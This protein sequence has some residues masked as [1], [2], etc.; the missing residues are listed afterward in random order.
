[1]AHTN[2]LRYV[3]RLARDTALA[4]AQEEPAP[5][6]ISR[7]EVLGG[8]VAAAATFMLPRFSFG[9]PDKDA[10]I[11]VVGAGISGLS[12]A[13]TLFD[14]GFGK[15]TTVYEASERIGGRMFSNSSVINANGAG[16]PGLAGKTYWDED[17][18]TEW[19]GELIDTPH[20]TVIGL[21][22]R[23]KLET[24]D[25]AKAEAKGS[26]PVS[27]FGGKY[28]PHSQAIKD[29]APV[30]A[31]LQKEVAAAV[32]KKKLDG[33]DNTDQ[34]VLYDAI[35]A[36]GRELDS[37]SISQWIDENVPGGHS[38]MLGQL[39]DAAYCSEYGAD[40]KEQSALNLVLV[41][42]TQSDVTKKTHRVK[43]FT[44]FGSSDERFHIVGGNQRLPIAIADFLGPD[45]V[46]KGM[47][48][49]KIALKSD[50]TYGLT[51]N[52]KQVV[53]DY[54]ALTLPFAV[55]ADK[56]DFSGAGFDQRKIMAIKEQGRGRCS[57]LQVQF[58]K[59]LWHEKGPWGVGNNGEE[60]FSDNG[61]Q[62]SWEATRGQPGTSGIINGYTGGTLTNERA[63]AAGVAFDTADNGGV[64]KLA[65]GLVSQL[66]QIFPGVKPLWN[67]KSTLS[68]PHLDP[69]F[70][71]SYA[72][73]KVGQYQKFAGYERAPQ[74]N[75]FFGGEH[76]SVNFQGFMEGGAAEGV[77]AANEILAA[78][79]KKND[80]SHGTRGLVD[81]VEGHHH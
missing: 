73:W 37:M 27:F 17:Q 62:C 44:D 18:V 55:L 74:K 32:P 78:V 69:N 66:D 71:L 24:K 1:M 50:G 28:Y 80:P 56:V 19:C 61:D 25:L 9:V 39:L 29:F 45:I 68:I 60:T 21:V 47:R 12:C 52:G 76:T 57:K 54:V 67:G 20:T 46:K 34:T 13:L 41:L 2:L 72:F 14:A 4:S 10:R 36:R 59:R 30:F 43:N 63:G 26:E 5:S 6:G 58:T 79:K 23:F 3:I 40:T 35:T 7:R 42:S 48:L 77:R 33:S 49:Q 11:A 65:G 8:A 64:A 38:S 51:I 31:K 70:G 75:C 22:S 81:D 16:F 15:N 53:A